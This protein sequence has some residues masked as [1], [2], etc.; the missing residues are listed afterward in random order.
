MVFN[1]KISKVRS[2][3]WALNVWWLSSL[4][5]VPWMLLVQISAQLA[6]VYGAL[7]SLKAGTGTG[8]GLGTLPAFLSPLSVPN[9]CLCAPSPPKAA[10]GT[11]RLLAAAGSGVEVVW[12]KRRELI[13][14]SSLQAGICL[15]KSF[16]FLLPQSWASLNEPEHQGKCGAEGKPTAG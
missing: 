13:T 11:W 3:D 2:A 12:G 10:A 1:Y 4:R 7:P 8:C 14:N 16:I 5:G 9:S 6:R 15:V